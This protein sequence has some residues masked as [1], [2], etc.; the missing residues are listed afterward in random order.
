[1]SGR[2]EGDQ[3]FYGVGGVAEPVGEIAV[4]P[5]RVP[6]PVGVL[7]RGGGVVGVRPGER[8]ERGEHDAISAGLV[9][10][11]AFV[12]VLDVGADLR[13]ERVRLGDLLLGVEQDR[14]AARTRR[15]GRR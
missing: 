2:V 14:G 5:R 1:M 12:A 3:L 7:V 13:E 15:P 8:L 9:V 4:E 10:G 11:A 6:G